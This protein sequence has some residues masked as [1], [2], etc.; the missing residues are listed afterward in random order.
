MTVLR[1]RL[2]ILLSCCLALLQI[3]SGDAV[4]QR[5]RPTRGRTAQAPAQ[6]QPAARRP[7]APNAQNRPS[8]NANSAAQRPAEPPILENADPATRA[9]FLKL[10]GANWIWSPAHPKDEVPVGDCYFRK[11]FPAQN[12]EL[13]QVHIACDNQYELYIN[14]RLAGRG[15]DWRKMDVHDITK[16]LIRGKNV[17]AIKA[18]NTDPGAAGLVARVIVKEKGGTF[19]S[20]STDDSWRTSVKLFGN[21]TQ[22]NVRDSEWLA[23]KVYGPLGGALPWGDEIVIADEGS[24]FLVD[25][26]FAIE[27]LVTDEQA[28]S[29]IAMAFTASGDILASQENGPLLMIRDV[30]KDG[31]LESVKPFCT[32]L[33]NVHGILPLGKRVYAVGDG[34]DGGALYQISD[35]DGDGRSDSVNTL[36]RYRGSL[37]E[38][39]PHTVRLGPDGLLYILSGNHAQAD[40]TFDPRSNYGAVYEGELVKPR[41][42]DPNGHAV[43]VPSPGGTILRTDMSGSFVE[44]VAGGFRNPFDFAFNGDGELFTYDADMEWDIGAPWYR[45]TRV[46]HV[47]PGAE[48]GWRSGWTK[49]PEYYIDSLPATLNIGPG[50]PTG[51]VYYDHVMYPVRLQNTLFIGD[52]ATGQ[53]H[54]VKLERNGAT[55]TAKY[56]TFVKGRPLNVT[57]LDVGPDGALYFSTGGRGTDGG[58]Y[59]VRWTGTVPPQ[60]IQFG[61]GI[62]QALHQPQLH[63]D[64]A[65]MRVAAVKRSLGDRWQSD[66]Q[67]VLLDPA[68]QPKLRQRALDLLTFFGPPPTPELLTRLARD[69]DPATRVRVARLMGAQTQPAFAQPLAKMLG[70]SDAWVR[71]VACESIARRI[72]RGSPDPAVP[73]DALVRLL[74]DPDRFVSFA[75]R[76]AL[77]KIPAGAWQGKVLAATDPNAFLQGATGLLVAHPSRETAQQILARCE[78]MMRGQ[79]SEPGRRPGEMSDPLF[80]NLLRVVQLA[81]I[82]GELQPGDVPGMT[83]QLVREYPTR[84]ALLNRELVRL[85]AYLQP[86]E[87]PAALARQIQSDIPAAEKLHIAGYAARMTSGWRTDD[88]LAMLRYYEEARGFEG[89][90]SLSG[91]I[92]NFARDFF[93]NL[94]LEERR[95]V[96]AAGE[97]FPTSGLSV[98]AKLPEN[99]GSEVLAEIRALDQRL[100]G[101]PGEPIARLRVGIVAVLGRSGEEQS[102]AYLRDVYLHNPQ[103][104]APVAMSLTQHPDGENW[105]ILVDSL[106]TVEGD[107]AKEVLTALTKV[108]RR[109]ETSEPYRNAILLGLRMQNGGGELASKLLK[110]WWPETPYRPGAALG[111]Q[112]AAWQNWYTKTF[113]NELP[114]E[115]PKETQPNKWSYEELASYLESPEGRA[116]SPSRGA[117]AFT[118]A[119]CI[120]CH[121]FNGRGEGIGPDLTTVAQRFQSKEILESIVYPNQVVSDQY[122]SQIVIAGGKTYTGIA[123]RSANGD[124]TV[125]QSDATK[126]ELAAA[127][128]ED[129][130]T[131]KTSSMPEGLLNTLTLEQVAD[132]F[133]FMMNSPEPGVATR[134]PG[135]AR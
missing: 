75:A 53:I 109:P 70:D 61:Q 81:L 31:T 92:E 14:G 8:N 30:D 23:A 130:Q 64:W 57:G 125:L 47:P 98:L 72:Q 128:I 43:G 99:P 83:Q 118:T 29:L 79:V 134:A 95:Q 114:A 112:L 123:A 34:P 102:L 113:P 10:I 35:D 135:A 18:T 68:S 1:V 3:L 69:A 7:A 2:A 5:Q 78:A 48:F 120:K 13:A 129:V 4:A 89:G 20:F 24:R 122:A 74:S 19:E 17:I 90:H 87:A 56:S 84:D 88:K 40:V 38:H 42:E 33:R 65:R 52:W 101:M 127:D 11:T 73:V 100:E 115:L 111:A 116:G 45:P 49:W 63:T 16:L 103:R 77:E 21:W 26:E 82:R 15:N 54:A 121:R 108:S 105:P 59:R 124:M 80:L 28:G 76:R 133:A 12:A 32:E 22:P 60:A 36:V 27:R 71:R 117:Q 97:N 67:R 91:Y 86:P 131:S 44:I 39:G 37:G 6:R 132:L 51:V 9:A 25:R 104:R 46:N 110:H 50:S 126:V 94:T 107:A 85:L 58:I 55:Y 96:L 41:Y 66:L 93:T 106:R 119:Q 62:E